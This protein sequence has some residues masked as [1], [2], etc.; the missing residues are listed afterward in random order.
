M[1]TE[2]G[3]EY[4][5]LH[6]ADG[7]VE[8][9][10]RQL[11]KLNDITFTDKERDGFF[12]NQIAA[13]TRALWKNPQNPEGLCAGFEARGWSQPKHHLD[14]INPR[15][16]MP[17]T[18]GYAAGT[19]RRRV[20]LHED[21]GIAKVSTCYHYCAKA[22]TKQEARSALLARVSILYQ[23]NHLYNQVSRGR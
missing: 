6:N 23:R 9:L 1:L 2:Q 13:Q 3:Y 4:L 16:P 22:E 7:L 17:A 19:L 8:N 11:E 10:R 21:Q 14:T 18:Y 12:E 20:R 15:C 5:T